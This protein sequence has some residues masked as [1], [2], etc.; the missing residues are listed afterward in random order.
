ML[1]YL[2]QEYSFRIPY[3][4]RQKHINM[5]YC[6][7]LLFYDKNRDTDWLPKSFDIVQLTPTLY[8]N[9]IF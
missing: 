5:S 4:P 7:Q 3:K 2:I 1:N 8:L 9:I 6:I